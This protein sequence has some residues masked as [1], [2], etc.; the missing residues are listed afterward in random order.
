MFELCSIGLVKSC[1]VVEFCS[2]VEALLVC[3]RSADVFELCSYVRGLLMCS[4]SVLET[5]CCSAVH[6]MP[7]PR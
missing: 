4:S 1:Y 3:S 6:A 7:H 2:C 5:I